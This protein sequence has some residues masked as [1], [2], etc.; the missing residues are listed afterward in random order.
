VRLY[1]VPVREE[2]WLLKT[3]MLAVILAACAATA[4][5]RV[6]TISQR[7]VIA[8]A[9]AKIIHQRWAIIAARVK[10]ISARWAVII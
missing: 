4:Q 9:R 1:G 7:A 10:I 2:R 8:A 6:K 3:K 5:L